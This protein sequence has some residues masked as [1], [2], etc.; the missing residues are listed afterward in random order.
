MLVQEQQKYEKQTL[1]PVGSFRWQSGGM[2]V[3]TV[4][5]LLIEDNFGFLYMENAYS[6]KALQI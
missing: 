4:F 5:Y 2:C 3:V 1:R 6:E